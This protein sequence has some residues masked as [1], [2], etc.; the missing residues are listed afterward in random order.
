MNNTPYTVPEGFFEKAE[1]NALAAASKISARRKFATVSICGCLA[2]LLVFS[3][4]T[5]R[6][7]AI[8]SALACSSDYSDEEILETYDYDVF[9]NIINF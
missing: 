1:S 3:L 2:L 5:P 6:Q 9:L 8:G 7:S 4:W